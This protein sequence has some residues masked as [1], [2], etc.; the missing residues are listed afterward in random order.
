MRRVLLW[1]LALVSVGAA[2]F[3]WRQTLDLQAR[4]TAMT[5]QTN[6]ANARLAD[7]KSYE[8]AVDQTDRAY[9]RTLN[10]QDVLASDFAE[11][12]TM[13]EQAELRARIEARL[14]KV[15]ADVEPVSKTVRALLLK[16]DPPEFTLDATKTTD[17][18]NAAFLAKVDSDPAYTKTASGLRY[19]KLKTVEQGE[20]PTPDNEVTVH[21][22]G[23]FIEGTEFDS[24]YKRN[25]PATFVLKNLING[26]IEG[27]PLMK[28]GEVIELV[29]PY[30]LAYGVGGR[31]SIPPRQ[32]LVF[33]VELLDIKPAPAP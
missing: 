17:E 31:G 26:W 18:A 24:S 14:A 2:V 19:R 12:K 6:A 28:K 32:T 10:S 33:Q 25:T 22:K 16:Q 29:L 9:A 7:L 15:K 5:E 27:I 21:Y 3:F 4:L 11:L 8:D 13:P 30:R 1:L 23:A 20:Q